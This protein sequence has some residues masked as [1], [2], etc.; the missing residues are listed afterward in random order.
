M[1]RIKELLV[2]ATLSALLIACATAA[3]VPR[4]EPP[5]VPSSSSQG[6]PRSITV[7]GMGKVSVVPDVARVNAGAE[8]EAATVFEAKAEVDRRMVAVMA[9]LNGIGI[10]DNDIQSSY[11]SIHY[12][13]EP[14]HLMPEDPP[15]ESQSGYRVSSLLCLTVRDLERAGDVLDAVVEAGANHVHGVTFTASDESRWHGKAREKA[16]ADAEARAGELARL[17]GVELG[18]VQTVSEVIGPWPMPTTMIRE[19]GM[20][21]AFAPGELELSTQVQVAYAIQ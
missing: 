11:F 20:G 4:S 18:A 13:R 10:D 16:M 3:A 12:E 8:A 21:G 15:R 17:A 1:K 5:A 2:V 19:P 7:V 6:P 14:M 9:A